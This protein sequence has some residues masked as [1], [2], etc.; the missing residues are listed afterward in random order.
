VVRLSWR[1]RPDQPAPEHS[2]TRQAD[3]RPE[4]IPVRDQVT[5]ATVPEIV[6]RV[7]RAATT[8][9]VVVDLTGISGFDTDGAAE[10]MRVQEA[11]TAG[12]VTLVGLRQATARLIGTDAV[13][14]PPEQ[15]SWEPWV[16]RR[17]RAIVVV[18]SDGD[19]AAS[20]DD[21]EPI[22]TSAMEEEVGIVVVDLRYAILTTAGV[23]VIAFASST[24]AL[25][26]QELLIVNADAEAAE[27]LR[28]AGLSATTYVAPEPLPD[29]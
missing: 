22:L 7:E 17:L 11:Y 18:Q 15:R 3:A 27:R 16:L 28:R 14:A 2:P 10:L 13:A 21:L 20:T 6:A 29:S 12:R 1:R 19:G 26:G 24:A 5:R 4:V 25:R 9:D 23:D 8:G